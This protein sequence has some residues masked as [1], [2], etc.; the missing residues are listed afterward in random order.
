MIVY[1]V[2]IELIKILHFKI[3]KWSLYYKVKYK[4]QLKLMININ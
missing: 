2:L 4:K 1:S 3:K